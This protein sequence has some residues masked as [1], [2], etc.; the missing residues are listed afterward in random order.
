[1]TLANID[2][3]GEVHPDQFW[4][5]YSLGNVK[6][7]PFGEIWTDT[8]D[9]VMGILKMRKGRIKGRCGRCPYFEICGGN[10]RVRAEFVTGDLWAEDPACYL[11]D[12]E[13]GLR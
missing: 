11:T 12:E 4:S 2:N 10:Y 5:H 8:S 6:K 1:M 3:M 13:L 7:R 9:P